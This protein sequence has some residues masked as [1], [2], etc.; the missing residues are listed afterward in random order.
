MFGTRI[1]HTKSDILNIDK[2]L[3]FTPGH[4]VSKRIILLQL[5]VIL[6]RLIVPF[7]MVSKVLSATPPGLRQWMESSSESSVLL[8]HHKQGKDLRKSSKEGIDSFYT[9]CSVSAMC[10]CYG[11][12]QVTEPKQ[13]IPGQLQ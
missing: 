10:A 11:Y 13:M 3:M 9:D 6:L 12:V 4:T 1:E 2:N 8:E 7:W 5:Q